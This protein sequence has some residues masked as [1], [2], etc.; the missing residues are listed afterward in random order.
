MSE[1]KQSKAAANKAQAAP[2]PVS[3][4]DKLGPAL[5][6]LLCGG[7]FLSTG[8]LIHDTN[9]IVLGAVFAAAAV[10]VAIWRLSRP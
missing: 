8:C 9:M 2:A 7:G 4:F 5:A 6:I 1:D 10:G 3:L